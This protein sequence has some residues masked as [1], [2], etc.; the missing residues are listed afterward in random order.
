MSSYIVVSLNIALAFRLETWISWRTS[1]KGR[2]EGIK[3]GISFL[4][5]SV[6]VLQLARH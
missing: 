4:V 1:W 3:A 6:R 2:W 5:S